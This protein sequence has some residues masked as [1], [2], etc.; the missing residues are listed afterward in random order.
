MS[1]N[2]GP[3]Y[4]FSGHQTFVFRYGWLEKGVQGVA[5]SPTIFS[6]DDAMVRLGVG[7]NMVDS[8]RHWCFVTQLVEADLDPN[9]KTG[10]NIRV[11]DMGHRLL[12]EDGWDP[13][14]Q[15][16]ASLWLVHW[17]LASNPE[18]GTTWQILFSLFHRPDF[19]K[20]ELV[21]YLVLFA[22]KESLRVRKS[23]LGRDVDCFLRT[24]V[25]GSGSKKSRLAEETFDCPLV[26]LNLVQQTPD[27]E[28]YRFAI[29]PK[30][31][32]PAAVFGY[33]LCEYFERVKGDRN[34]MS[35]QECLYGAGS[36]GQAFKLDENILIEYVEELEDAS[37][38]A[39]VLDETAGLKQIFRLR[40][41]DPVDML[42]D[43][44]C[45]VSVT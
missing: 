36:P 27:G 34:S 6:D 26:E 1:R 20:R 13:F 16:D 41:Q 33:A 38:K 30:P 5:A 23:V 45:G 42:E 19:T 29:G 37:N 8:I 18:I 9:G 35:I 11:T 15:D 22:E 24:Y 39:I 40:K 3:R 10:R 25:R 32:L 14:L 4:R 2:T 31:S 44:Y 7:K 12:L 17:L 43:Y 21:D 28:L